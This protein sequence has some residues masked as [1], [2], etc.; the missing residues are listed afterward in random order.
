MPIYRLLN[1]KAAADALYLTFS[2]SVLAIPSLQRIFRYFALFIVFALLLGA[3]VGPAEVHGYQLPDT[4]Q[5]ECYDNYGN[6]INCTTFY[7]EDAQYE[8]D[9]PAYQ[10]NGNGTVTDL[11]TGL[12][13]QQDG[14]NYGTLGD[15]EHYCTTLTLGGYTDWRIPNRRELVSIVD[16]GQYNPSINTGVFSVSAS[17]AYW[18]STPL[19]NVFLPNYVWST[20]FENGLVVYNSSNP[21]ALL[22]V[23]CV[24]GDSLPLGQFI[25]NGDGTVI[26]HTTGLIWERQGWP[27][28]RFVPKG[29]WQDALADCE[30]L[31]LA[32][33]DDWRLPNI[34]ELE[35]LVDFTRYNPTID[36]AAFN[37]CGNPPWYEIAVRLSRR[38]ELP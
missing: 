11:N 8:G 19:V 22:Y 28:G 27:S 31:I 23:R 21:E 36:S 9:Q 38:A 5:T 14:G 18:S 20:I 4:G 33:Y 24:R 17:S 26:D 13:W 29:T 37:C 1:W 3:G 30:N 7:G 32:G 25:D 15:A 10:D 35:S 6:V 34:R 16:Y 2:D 12:M